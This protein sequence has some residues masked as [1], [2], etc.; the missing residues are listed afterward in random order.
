MKDINTGGSG[1][2]NI[3]FASLGS[4]AKFIDT[5]KYHFSSLGS[6]AST[7]D[8]LEK[9]RV[10]KLTLQFL[11][12]YDYFSKTWL[13]LDFNQKRN[14]LGIIVSEKGVISYVKIVSI[15]SLNIKLENGICFFLQRMNF[16]ALKR[17]KRW[18]KRNITIQNYFILFKNARHV[19]F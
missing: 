13:L 10:E 4:Q 3:N 2:T 19:H 8:N 14:V 7:L 12:Q 1:L 17:E 11:N 5:M 15:C 16:V 9:M 18:M 6:L